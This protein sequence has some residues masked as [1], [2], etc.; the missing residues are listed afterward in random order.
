MLTTPVANP[1]EIGFEKAWNHIRETTAQIRTPVKCV[2]CDYKKICGACA[3][4]YYTE[5]GSF[6]KVPEYVLLPLVAPCKPMLAHKL[7]YKF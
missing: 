6:E 1:L 7:L 3:A 4:V 2:S 5:T